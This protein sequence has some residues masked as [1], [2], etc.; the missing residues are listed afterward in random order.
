M[1]RYVYVFVGCNKSG[2]LKKIV[3]LYSYIK[4]KERPK[5]IDLN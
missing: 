3:T 1:K 2:I 5:C 4:I